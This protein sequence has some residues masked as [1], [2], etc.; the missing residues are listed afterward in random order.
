MLA[1]GEEQQIQEMEA[2]MRAREAGADLL[3]GGGNTAGE[4]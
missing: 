3:S 4:F 1:A 2:E